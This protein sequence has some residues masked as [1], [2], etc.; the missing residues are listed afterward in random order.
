MQAIGAIPHGAPG[1]AH[2]GIGTLRGIPHGGHHGV[3][4]G[5]PHGHGAGDPH[6]R[7]VGDPR[8]DGHRPDGDGVGE[9]PFN[10]ITP[11]IPEHLAIMV[12]HHDPEPT[13]ATVPPQAVPPATIARLATAILPVIIVRLAITVLPAHQT[14]IT[15]ITVRPITTVIPTAIQTTTPTPAPDATPQ[16]QVHLAEAILREAVSAEAP[17]RRVEVAAADVTDRDYSTTQVI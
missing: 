9:H 5:R 10:L 15:T 8:G 12:W 17:V 14:V 2:P 4:H 7:G 3:G 13:A 6:G 16:A 11:V 1:M